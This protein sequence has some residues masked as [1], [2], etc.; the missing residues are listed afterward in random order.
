MDDEV[1]ETTDEKRVAPRR[2][3]PRFGP[4]VTITAAI[5]LLFGA[6]SRV[7]KM[8]ETFA[9]FGLDNLASS[10]I[11][12]EEDR[13]RAALHTI[14]AVPVQREE[15]HPPANSLPL[16][17]NVPPPYRGEVDPEIVRENARSPLSLGVPA[18]PLPEERRVEQENWL[19][20]PQETAAPSQ[21]TQPSQPTHY[22]VE[23]GDT[24]N[25]I[26][27]KTL[28]DG[29]RW[30]EIRKANPSAESGLTVGMRL[31]IPAG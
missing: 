1:Q 25:K 19:R 22:L 9:L 12:R 30:Q 26:A 13:L 17:P 4:F 18:E 31:V 15:L 6:A 29:K 3:H 16:R 23:S 11:Q 5:L 7:G 10:R 2:N 24:W 20:P 21:P 27:K 28:G 8:E 14:G